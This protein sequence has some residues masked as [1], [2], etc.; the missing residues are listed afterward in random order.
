DAAGNALTATTPT[1]ANETYDVDNT[2]PAVTLVRADGL[3]TKLPGA[4]DVTVT[5][6]EANGLQT[7]GAG[8]FEAD[9]LQVTN[10]AATLTAT[11]DPLVWTARV[12]PS[13]DFT[14]DV[15][16]DLPAG[17]VQ[18]AAGND[19]TA[20]TPL[21]VPVD[22]V[23]PTVIVTGPG[24]HDG[25]MAFDVSVVFSEA[26]TG[27]ADVA[28]LAIANGALTS[29]AA[30]IAAA[31]DDDDGTR[32]KANV[33][34]SGADDV[35]VQVIAGAASDGVNESVA[36]V[37]QNVPYVDSEEPTVVSVARSTPAAQVTNAD[38][39]AW[40]VTFSE[41]VTVSAD[42]FGVS[43]AL[44]GAAVLATPATSA[45][46]ATWTVEV[47]GG[48]AIAGHNGAVA[49]SLAD[50][51]G[52][53][54]A[55]GNALTGVLPT[56]AEG[57]TLDNTGPAA[58]LARADGL[59]TKLPGAFDVTVTFT[60]ANGLQTTGAGA[61]TAD[62]LQVTNG[63]ATLTSTSDPLVWTATVT[64]AADFT[65]DVQ[66]DL[67]AGRVQD[68]AG[69]ANSAATQLSVAVD[70]V[71]PTATVTGPP[72]H[73]G[74][75]PFDVQVV[76]SEAVSGFEEVADLAIT[77]GGL[78]S[79][80]ASIVG[81]GDD[82]GTEYT[83]NVTP[84]SPDDVTVQVVAGAASDGVHA[85]AASEAVSI[86]YVDSEDPT[87]VSVARSTPAAQVT[88]ADT[89]AWTVTFSE[90]VTVG[91]GGFGVSPALTGAT[92]T[93]TA[94]DSTGDATWTVQ[95]SG[96]TAIAG[97]NGAV[98]LSLA[99]ALLIKDAADNALSGGLP[100][101]AEGF[102]LDNTAPAVALTRADGLDTTLPGAYDVT[103]TFTEAN[104]LQ[105]TGA[106]AFAADDLQVT[107]GAATLTATA[108]PLV[109]TAKVTPDVG[110]TGDVQVDL[111]AGR[112]Q[113]AAGNDNTAA[114]QL[115]VAVD[116]VAPTV[117]VAV[118][119]SHDGATPFDVTVE[120]SEAV[121]GFADVADL[122]I[123]N[124]A[125]TSGAASIAAAGDNDGTE[126]TVNVTP[127]SPADVTVQVV[128]GAA[129]DG[130]HASVV[131]QSAVV[132]YVDS[133]E[134]TVVSVER[135]DGTSAQAEITNADTL[136]FRVTFSEAVGNVD[137]TD[138]AATGATAAT[139]SS[140]AAVAG[141]A[142]QAIVTVNGS[143]LADYDGTV[144]L[145]FASAQDITDSAGNA[146]NATLPTG[147][148]YETYTVDNTAPTLTRV[149]RSD[150]DGVDPGALTNADSLGF[151]VTFSEG[152][153]NVDKT[154]FAASGTSATAS[155][156]N[157]IFGAGDP[158]QYIVTVGLGTHVGDLAGYNGKV[159]LAFAS[160]Q[161]IA[162]AAGNALDVTLP[163]GPGYEDYTLDNAGP[164]AALA[165]ADGLDTTLPGA[166]DVTVTFTEANGLQ[167]TGAGAF[168]A[169]DLQVTNGGATLTATADPLVWTAKVT[170]QAGFTG[171]VQV[172]LAAGRV[173][174]A[175]GNA[176]TAAA[177]LSVP[178]D[179]VAPTV[180]VTGP[181]SHDG[182]TAFDVEVVFSEVV[183]GFADVADL[184]IT[185]G[186]LTSGA[187]S[188][189]A[190]S[191][192]GTRYK[193]NVTPSGE[194]DVTVQVVAGAASDGV[195]V[196]V[197]S[198]SLP[199]PY[200]DS[201][202]PTVVSVARSTPAA[203]VTNSDTLAWTV[204]FSE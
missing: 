17:R 165:R 74:G 95:V 157:P 54:D 72:S 133:K 140:A 172:D 197:A 161:D 173:Q 169:D 129:S 2:A 193:A 9:D 64:P 18:D 135:H 22:T 42:A 138:F 12:T 15:Q 27:F 68:A 109:W 202:D 108:D 186:A 70:T 77:N 146:L 23:A 66:V 58:A 67:P 63:A 14:G 43:P 80:A 156:V 73:D 81:A 144:G 203:Q 178:V 123:T 39:L 143:A 88:N 122:A 191:N 83:V 32:Y 110:F 182:G 150:L 145:A 154:D 104:G 142:A 34:P 75:T 1:G 16:V 121:T 85:S 26:V 50:G 11:S 35:T 19:N 53:T 139:V 155:H 48:T 131:S 55:A 97:H 86:D 116:T 167:T 94:S 137:E 187:S 100:T 184:A 117:T 87:V 168:T 59:D 112:V 127:S 130:V 28:D 8:A 106:G 90:A 38:T 20:A 25:D 176:N 57:F 115:T 199:V 170:P 163:T 31:D 194:D 120:F 180:I 136:T 200:V 159:G 152:V 119:A 148:S 111:A 69:N 160:G 113:D 201:E 153:R 128:A 44:A 10:G 175:A 101:D 47:S 185:G 204:T 60:E 6:T 189:A 4:F 192:D 134:P 124:G 174:D 164:A 183:T 126:F 125:L 179:T 166:F 65:G 13:E 24:S 162:D 198:Q 103:V 196:S 62:D 96:G 99:D 158:A 114:V 118:P 181:G 177:Q 7:T 51:S 188:I 37:A 141:N 91:P 151:W 82:D 149:E 71:A 61:F 40:T 92:V 102:T 36:S 33:T 41:P 45:P 52:I 107:N 21:S 105:T 79:G 30:S 147:T 76:F 132:D 84:T 29:G 89:L 190:D 171:D 195:N 93:V 5:F 3:D 56:N 49:L 98:A 46:D 78:T